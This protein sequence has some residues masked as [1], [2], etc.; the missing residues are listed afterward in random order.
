MGDSKKPPERLFERTADDEEDARYE[1][2]REAMTAKDWESTR[3]SLQHFST[4][5]DV[6]CESSATTLGFLELTEAAA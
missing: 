3:R 2:F 5:R 6:N 4:N 1:A